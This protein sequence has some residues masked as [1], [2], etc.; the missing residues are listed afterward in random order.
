M[1]TKFELTKHDAIMIAHNCAAMS[2]TSKNVQAWVNNIGN[3]GMTEDI[4]EACY[5][6]S[7]KVSSGEVGIAYVVIRITRG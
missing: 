4:K 7:E 6:A 1:P 5:E 2:E 3:K